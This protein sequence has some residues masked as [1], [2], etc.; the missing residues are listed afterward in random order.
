MARYFA[1]V[2][3]LSGPFFYVDSRW[4]GAIGV[5]ESRGNHMPIGMAMS[6]GP[7]GAGVTRWRLTVHGA[8]VPGLFVVVDREFRPG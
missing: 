4:A 8:E 7:D 6:N 3:P 2:G 5:L 1:N